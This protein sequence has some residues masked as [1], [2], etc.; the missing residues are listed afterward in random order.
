MQINRVILGC[1]T[2][3]EYLPFWNLTSKAWKEIIG[4]TPTLVLIADEIPDYLD[5]TYGE[6][7]L[8]KPIEGIP[9]ARQAQIVRF[10]FPSMFPEEICLTSDIDMFPLSS[11]YFNGLI[12]QVP[13]D[14]LAVYS[15]DS[16]MP[17][18]PN[19]PSFAVGYNAAKGSVFEEIVQGNMD[20]WETKLKE[21]VSEGHK[22]FTDE[23]MFYNS[24]SNWKPRNERT[25]FFKRGYN[26]HP[27][28]LYINRVDRGNNCNFDMRLLAMGYYYDFHMPRPYSRYKDQIHEIVNIST[29]FKFFK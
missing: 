24:W 1:D 13:E 4:V 26:K 3:L 21:W 9:T 14:N 22:W 25:S 8:L 19:H 20:T 11:T 18:F 16:T 15:S 17:G 6:I 2:H 28:P 12:E 7:H 23:I 5:R 29:D 27:D 10:F